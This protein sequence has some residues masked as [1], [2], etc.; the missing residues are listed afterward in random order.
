MIKILIV[1]DHPMMRQA[2]RAA[3]EDEADMR[4][5]GEAANGLEA[6]A[7][8]RAERPDVIL[9]DLMM[10]VKDGL[11]AISDIMAEE[12]EARILVFTSSQEE[13]MINA[14]VEAGVLG[15]LI[16]D[17][18][19]SELLLAIREVSQGRAYLSPQIASKLMSV[20]RKRKNNHPTQPSP[21]SLTPRETE[22]LRWVG[23]GASNRQI[24][25]ALTLSEGTVRTHVHNILQK[26]GL[27]NRYQAILLYLQE[28]TP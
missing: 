8:V 22:I 4:L 7:A 28:N 12:P 27:K 5:V 1:D 9:M 23:Q 2:L 20:M 18:Q 15:Y 10:P 17:A 6:V 16:K 24:A 13:E 11:A 3:V 25:E 26:L 19:L 21:E 14:A